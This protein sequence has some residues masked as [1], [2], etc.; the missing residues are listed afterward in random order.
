M[1]PEHGRGGPS[2][3]AC[4]SPRPFWSEWLKPYY[5][6]DGATIY[7]GDCREVMPGLARGVDVVVTDPPYGETSLAWDVPVHDW[8]ALI[9]GLLLPSGSLWCFGS[10]RM[11]MAASHEF[12]AW[13]LAQD[14]IWEKQNGSGFHA[15]RFRRVHEHVVQFYLGRWDEV[16]HQPVQTFDASRRVIRRQ[17]ARPPHMGPGKLEGTRY[18][19]EDGGPRLMRSVIAITS[20]HGYAQHPTQKPLGI[21]APLLEYSCPPGGAVLDCFMGSGSTLVAARKMGL[22][23]VGVDLDERC[24]EMAANRL[25]QGVLE[26]QS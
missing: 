18:Q 9:R 21:I 7:H 17:K 15:D 19:S 2:R 5:E 26:L 1:S 4:G 3:V 10:L 25:A 22:T 6:R 8:L 12:A 23:G 11:F 14:V 16:Y 24:C 20:C 13:N